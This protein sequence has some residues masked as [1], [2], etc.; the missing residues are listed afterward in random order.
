[1][2]QQE[3]IV[4]LMNQ[5]GNKEGRQVIWQRTTIQRISPICF[6]LNRLESGKDDS[7]SEA[8][9]QSSS[10]LEALIQTQNY[11]F[12]SKY[13]NPVPL[14]LNPFPPPHI[15]RMVSCA[16]YPHLRCQPY[17]R[18]ENLV[19]CFPEILRV[20]IQSLPQAYR[21]RELAQTYKKCTENKAYK[22]YPGSKFQKFY[23]GISIGRTERR[24]KQE[25]MVL[26][27]KVGFF[28]KG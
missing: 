8:H 18:T 25:R 15:S 3:S 20:E 14:K 28:L 16:L 17:K 11:P 21:P 7:S 13:W 10:L 24:L 4:Q 12:L 23:F 5:W 19:R 6:H 27:G 1:M 2:D 26:P 9:L 22:L